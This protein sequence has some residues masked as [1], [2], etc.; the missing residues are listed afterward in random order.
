M[1]EIAFPLKPDMQ[2]ATVVD[3][4]DA[5]QQCLARGLLALADDEDRA[6]R[7]TAALRGERAEQTYGDQTRTLV[8]AFQEAYQL[9]ATGEVDESTAD[10]LNALLRDST[11]PDATPA[12]V[13]AG[14]VRGSQ[15][16]SVEGLEAVVVDVGIGGTVA[17]ERGRLTPLGAFEI[18]FK[19]ACQGKD[20]PD[21][22]VQICDGKKVLA[23]SAVRIDAPPGRVGIDVDMPADARGGR[24]EFDALS[25]RLR[26]AGTANV[27]AID[28]TARPQDL[29][30]LARKTQWDARA[31]AML[32]VAQRMSERTRP[33]EHLDPEYFYALFRAG[34]P[35][36]AEAV[37]GV[38]PAAAR[39][40]W[41]AAADAGIIAPADEKQLNQAAA[42][43]EALIRSE[44]L[45]TPRV[46]GA[47]NLR[48][49]LAVSIGDDVAT[50][51]Q[52]LELLAQAGDD[53]PAFWRAVEN[54][55]GSATRR[56]LEVDNELAAFTL[57]NAPLMRML[58]DRALPSEARSLESLAAAGLARPRAWE[59]LLQDVPIPER[60]T[61][62]TDSDRRAR[63]AEVLAAQ[64]RI[65]FPLAALAYRV[66]AG[67]LV[68]Q[69]L[70]GKVVGFLRE[71]S[72]KYQI[73][74]EPL[75]R[76]L[77]RNGTQL[78]SAEHHEIRRL[79]RVYQLTPSDDAMDA[80]LEAG[81]DSAYQIAQ[82]DESGFVAQL[83]GTVGGAE[84]AAAIHAKAREIH[85]ATVNVVLA[86]QTSRAAVR[87]GN[88][89]APM[90]Q[91][92]YSQQAMMQGNAAVAATLETLFGE[93]D[94][95]ACEH[96]RSVLSPAAY[97]V[98]LL[99]LC[100]PDPRDVP[101]GKRPPIDELRRRRPDIEHLPLTCANTHTPLPIIDLV[102]E[103][104]EYFVVAAPAERPAKPA[105]SLDGF[106]GYTTSIDVSPQDLLTEPQ[107]V[108]AAA[109]AGLQGA[110]FPLALPFNEPLEAQRRYLGPFDRTLAS[111]M[112]AL[113][114][115]EDLERSVGVPFGWRDILMEELELSR[116]QHA[117]LT[118][119][120][121]TVRLLYGFAA[122]GAGDPA[123]PAELRNAKHFS[124]RL[125]ITYEELT[126]LLR[127]RFVNPNIWVLPLAE[128]LGVTLARIKQFAATADTPGNNDAFEASVSAGLDRTLYGGSIAAWTRLHAPTILGLL[129][130]HDPSAKPDPC[131]FDRMEFRY[132]DPAANGGT[133]RALE[134]V[135]LIR[136]VRLWKALAWP[137]PPGGAD[138]NGARAWTIA[139]TD[140][141]LTALWP[142]N[143]L[144]LAGD[145]ATDLQRLD[146]GMRGAL[147]RLGALIRVMRLLEVRD[148]TELPAVLACWAPMQGIE[149]GSLYR[150][151]FMS[152]EFL[153]LYPAFQ[154][155]GAGR[156]LPGA[157]VTLTSQSEAL[158]AACGLTADE[159][160]AVVRAPA[161]A[162]NALLASAP[163]LADLQAMLGRAPSSPEAEYL[164]RFLRTETVSAVFRRAWLA[165]ALRVS[166]R[167]L[168]LLA[169]ATGLDPFADPGVLVTL[170]PPN[171]AETFMRLVVELRASGLTPAEALL[172]FFNED[173]LAASSASEASARAFASTLRSEFADVD[174]ALTVTDDPDSALAQSLLA[175]VYDGAV[176]DR[177]LAYINR[178]A[179]VDVEYTA[180]GGAL[181]A[182]VLQASDGGLSYDDFTPRLSY[183]KGVMPQ[184]VR[185]ALIDPALAQPQ[186]FTDAMQALFAQT[187][188]FL[189]QL[190]PAALRQAHD[191]FQASAAPEPAK[192]R[193][194]LADLIA[195]LKPLR[196]RRAA[197]E[198]LT[199]TLRLTGDWPAS[200]L[201]DAS[202]LPANRSA[203]QP[204]VADL[205]AID[206][207][208]VI[209]EF[210]FGNLGATP[211]VADASAGALEYRANG[212]RS[213]PANGVNPAQPVAGR[214]RG[215]F[216]VPAPGAFNLFIELDPA[217]PQPALWI[218]GTRVALQ[219]ASA[220]LWRTALQT[221]AAGRLVA[222]RLEA[223][224]L[225][226]RASL[227][228]Q[229]AG[230]ARAV[231]AADDL[232]AF[233]AMRDLT[234]TVGRLQRAELLRTKLSL[235][236]PE[237][238]HL[239]R[240]PELRIT[241]GANAVAWAWLGV[242]PVVS[243]AIGAVAVRLGQVLRALLAYLRMRRELSA[244]PDELLAMLADP[245]ATLRD[246][247]AAFMR[248]AAWDAAA[249]D[250][251]LTRFNLI[252]S[253]QPDRAALR[254]LANLARVH[255]A[256]L[257]V[258]ALQAPYPLVEA[259]VTNSP[260]DADVRTLYSALRS[261]YGAA[262]WATLMK[263]INDRVRARRRDALVASVLHA[264][265]TDPDPVRRTVDTAD[266]LYEY[267][268]LDSQ[269]HP[270]V[271]TSRIRQALASVQQFIQRC[272][273]I[274]GSE[275]G[276]IH[277][278]RAMRDQWPWMKRYRVWEANRKVFL[279]PENWMEP[280]LRD[281]QSGIFR[282]TMSE[283][284]QGD[285]TEE[286][287]A[288]AMIGYLRKLEQLVQ[289]EPAAI[290]VD[291][292]ET[293]STTDDL[294]HVIAR[295]SGAN[296]KYYYRRR[297]PG[298]WM[299]WQAVKLDI[300]DN[301]VLPLRWKNRLFIFWV[302]VIQEANTAKTPS[303]AN[304]SGP[305]GSQ[306]ASAVPAGVPTHTV[307]AIL[308][309]S[310]YVGGKWTD[311]RTSSPGAAAVVDS[312]VTAMG[313]SNPFVRSEYRLLA[314][315]RAD[316][317]RIFFGREPEDGWF[318]PR[319]AFRLFN[320]FAEPDLLSL[321]GFLGLLSPRMRLPL[322]R[323]LHD[324]DG[325]LVATYYLDAHQR[326]Y[327]H[328]LLR[329]ADWLFQGGPWSV[330]GPRHDTGESWHDTAP[331]FYWD[332]RHTLFI[333]PTVV[334]LTNG[335]PWAWANNGRVVIGRSQLR[336]A[337]D[338]VEAYV[339]GDAMHVLPPNAYV[340][341]DG[342]AVDAQGVVTI[343]RSLQP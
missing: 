333:T 28:V 78:G 56:R 187:R 328:P 40:T 82:L 89:N 225:T 43:F 211:D 8:R 21:L 199:A 162:P 251:V 113:R 267:L 107:H 19:A 131:N 264:L 265:R 312:N 329:R 323:L 117:I 231:I 259:S 183:S 48:E 96:C 272:V 250:R 171:P 3:L 163:T 25:G 283:L 319:C 137:A 116:E 290:H 80:V 303:F 174:R 87:I 191:A 27:A 91:S 68:K 93:L 15:L 207:P 226:A 9:P 129:T 195:A 75:V 36:Q 119:R 292:R 263:P 273:E 238:L 172:T 291:S 120:T 144:P 168:D 104:L 236:E 4:Q 311:A 100:D 67:A 147:L 22:A 310:E 69:E 289:L 133:V 268:L 54:R 315:I 158:R 60:I 103:T 122:A 318:H 157:A 277:V 148:R 156:P 112:E 201:T 52:L 341:L 13:V 145:D 155:D 136:F 297:D 46:R 111:M 51:A 331:F 72:G 274:P 206:Q 179:R 189:Q 208:G 2:G 77:A 176:A 64:V 140:A 124:R 320:S 166:P 239:L 118:D 97:L 255:A 287:A 108:R 110:R 169:R 300:E 294:L 196:K 154:P 343:L 39:E 81:L 216:R 92:Q 262:D 34:I 301:P 254:S 5:L 10:A 88:A 339:A 327:M 101:A 84:V 270:R 74:R 37:L 210:F 23:T 271:E 306:P 71:H 146:D 209:G 203:S 123:V 121:L 50:E 242:I 160:T 332:S 217:A 178:R 197:I 85:T 132:G 313:G 305:L 295:S 95:C 16:A 235:S 279:Y 304:A 150:R 247:T 233:D 98:D 33:G 86:F 130:L 32:I 175:S 335:S 151:L 180:P 12:Y 29:A 223:T 161:F 261:R 243:P 278:T 232:F 234:S 24:S 138:D 1:K 244:Q 317:L 90:V 299:P 106:Q 204:G 230:A 322:R 177:Y 102:N 61:G 26:A 220:G 240:M 63:Y 275:P 252:A 316:E 14:Q 282:E 17:L 200:V 115:N 164:M 49:L 237:L 307:K 205:L 228:L 324:K 62:D 293:G 334:R 11:V 47:S 222:F 286:R 321:E 198:R 227:M 135:R 256:L 342:R 219:A 109:Y 185:D 258:T 308:C 192:R 340:E 65:A 285:I 57:H 173:L 30:Y 249:V 246:P 142:V 58:R 44:G 134:F 298:S 126:A 167:E 276:D 53:P 83:E 326:S 241:A 7:W 213:L 184:A 190:S 214:W 38:T 42:R 125:G 18:A 141:A 336:R 302:K 35:A 260:T 215:F 153:R 59:P 45:T 280:E 202:S 330:C 248:R 105:M 55:L 229:I 114:V 6:R 31:V 165:R 194:L 149:E 266:R 79:E 257:P 186:L 139:E 224:D 284:L 309:W 128:R 193:Q 182:A 188:V 181:A 127:T 269:M 325:A 337:E 170:T 94:H 99:A 20:L 253:G 281:D 288:E 338:A 218:E 159:W 143:Q 76:Y 152:I 212:P 41:K 73:G 70:K 66:D 296:R 245:V 221:F 314:A